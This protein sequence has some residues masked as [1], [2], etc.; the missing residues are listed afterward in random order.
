MLFH[1]GCLFFDGNNTTHSFPFDKYEDFLGEKGEGSGVG[2]G[3]RRPMKTYNIDTITRLDV[4]ERVKSKKNRNVVKW[5][6]ILFDG[7]RHTR[8]GIDLEIWIGGCQRAT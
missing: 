4:K 2:E 3:G 1:S 6:R 7:S 5:M 8:F